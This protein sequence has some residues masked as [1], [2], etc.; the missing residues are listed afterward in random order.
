MPPVG[1]PAAGIFRLWAPMSLTWLLMALEAPFLAA[2]IARLAAPELNLAAFG[3]AYAFALI[4]EAPVIMMLSAS[5]ALVSDAGSFDR[6]RRFAYA[7]NGATTVALGLLLVPPLFDLVAERWIGLGHDIAAPTWRALLWLLPW[8]AAIGYRRFYQGLLI[9]TDRTRRVA[10]GTAVRL[11]AMAGTGVA[12]FIHGGTEGAALG[13]L[14]LSAGVVAEALAARLL[15]APAVRELRDAP[16]SGAVLGYAAITRFYTPLA[17]TSTVSLA[18]HP[19]VTFFVGRARMP[20][21]SLAVLPVINGLTFIF[22]SIGLSY[23]EVA[24]ALLARGSDRIRPVT[25]F[26]TLL[27]LGASAGLTLIAFTPLGMIWYRDVSGLTPELARFA[28][29][30]T[31]IL[32]ILPALSVLLSLQRAVLVHGRRTGPVTGATVV[33]VAGIVAVLAAAVRGFDAVGAVA[34]ATALL[35][36]RLAGNLYLVPPCAAVVRGTQNSGG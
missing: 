9:R 35:A 27:A 30:P 19:L 3:V 21:E 32:V 29:P 14:A 5:T 18:V 34:A 24:I 16:P 33:E 25:R 11:V 20:I 28:L 15:A 12:L 22:R 26:A 8:P 1:D 7:L 31:R 17:L 36:G 13:A 4:A 23:Q 10:Y 6:V 2:L